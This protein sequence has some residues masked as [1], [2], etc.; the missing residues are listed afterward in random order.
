MV[1]LAAVSSVRRRS[2]HSLASS[3][4]VG[5]VARSASSTAAAYASRVSW[6][7]TRAAMFQRVGAEAGL[8][9]SRRWRTHPRRFIGKF[10]RA[11][12]GEG[13]YHPPVVRRDLGAEFRMYLPYPR[14]I[15]HD[16]INLRGGV[17]P[18][19]GGQAVCGERYCDENC[20]PKQ[21]S[22]G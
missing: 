20:C 10:S 15:C 1:A 13:C 12:G 21:H 7:T 9:Q 8:V 3:G 11:G 16:L 5:A 14:V 18:P 4:S 2:G 19:P 6:L 22:H 17:T